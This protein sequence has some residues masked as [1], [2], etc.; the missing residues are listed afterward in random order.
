MKLTPKT[1]R[2][3]L[4]G[5]VLILGTTIPSFAIFGLGDI[6][7]DPT[8][9]ASLVSQLT[10]LQQQ[11]ATVKANL[12]HFS[13]K[14]MWQTAKMQAETMN[15]G[16]YFGETAGMGVA[17]NTNNI[18]TAQSAWRMGTI[19]VQRPA[20]MAGQTPGS[21]AD[22]SALAMVETSDAVSPACLNAIGQYNAQRTTNLAAQASLSTS[23]LDGSSETNSEVQQLNLVNAAM[24]QASTEAMAQGSI[25]TCVAAQ[26][27]IQNMQQRNAEAQQINDAAFVAQQRATN[28]SAPGGESTTWDSYLP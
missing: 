5:G 21:S 16:N 22:L 11:Y 6:V 26:L 8:S 28:P 20:N 27:T 9:Y 17:L 15:V 24:A 23:Q 2:S 1:R 14:S 4:I 3:I 25:H 12:T 19:G 18:G 13:T 7:F 10:T